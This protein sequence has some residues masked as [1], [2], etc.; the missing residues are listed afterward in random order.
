MVKGLIVRQ[1]ITV[2]D[3]LSIDYCSL[4]GRKN[5]DVNKVIAQEDRPSALRAA[6][7]TESKNKAKIKY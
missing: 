4:I 7:K 1:K 6:V 3:S 5:L 2:T